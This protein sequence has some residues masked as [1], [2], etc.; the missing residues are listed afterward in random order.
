MQTIQQ[1]ETI[2]RQLDPTKEQRSLILEKTIGYT[3][4]F[5]N[6]L[7]E[8]PGYNGHYSFE[9]LSS[10]RIEEKGKPIEAILEV[11][12]TNVDAVGINSASGRHLGFI[13]GGGLWASSIADM[14]GDISNKY[15]GIAFSGPG[16]VKIESQV[17]QWMTGIIGYPVTAFGNLTSGGSIANLIAVKA[18]R[19]FYEINSTNVKETVIY[20][21]EQTH[22]SIYKALNITGLHEAVFRKIPL[23]KNFRIDINE[24]KKQIQTDKAAGLH[25]F[26]VIASAGTTDTGAVDPLNEIADICSEHKLWFHVDAA[27]GGFFM[28]LD[29]MKEKLKGIERSDSVVLDPHKTLFLPFGSGAVLLKDGNILLSSN[30]SKASYLADTED[31][32]DINPA[33]TGI[34][35][36]R[37]NRGLRM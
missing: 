27:Y 11:L 31:M 9:K 7:S 32:D 5:L 21:G 23:D 35:L 12:K 6:Q 29:E 20:F 25:P 28:L 33:D 16:S 19:D 34:E 4:H 13:P 10:M 22:H 8:L 18:A 37:P 15:A 14:L 24:L 30:S 26:L 2:A 3:N 17:I 36:T 1:L